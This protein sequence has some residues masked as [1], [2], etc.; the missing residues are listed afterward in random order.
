MIELAKGKN[1]D[2]AFITLAQS[3]VNELAS[4]HRPSEL[5]VVGVDNWF[6][7]KWVGFS[8][9]VL[10]ALGVWK[11]H[12]TVPPFV[13]SRVIGER[14]FVPDTVQEAYR[15]VA[16]ETRIHVS[17]PSTDN[18]NR[19]VKSVAPDAVLIWYSG[20]TACNHRGCVMA[21]VPDV[22]GYWTWYVGMTKGDDWRA[23]DLKGISRVELQRLLAT[24]AEA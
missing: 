7:H 22:D 21:Y 17:G 12:L 5:F 4:Q 14:H 24:T 20:N 19:R 9:K 15:E 16:T 2:P 10:G 18:L 8:G 13:P 23:S 1:D 6:D 11:R 3:I